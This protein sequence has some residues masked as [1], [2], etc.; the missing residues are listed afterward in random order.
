[1]TESRDGYGLAATRRLVNDRSRLAPIARLL[2][3]RVLSVEEGRVTVEFSIS[4]LAPVTQGPMV[5]EGHVLRKGR[6]TVF[7]EAV[8]RDLH[9]REYARAASVGAIR[10]TKA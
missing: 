3:A 4:F 10:R 6:S 8:L 5:G 2:G 9:G 1:M 7:M